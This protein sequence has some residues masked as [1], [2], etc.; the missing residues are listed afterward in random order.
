MR[1]LVLNAGYEPLAVVSFKRALVL[2]LGGKASIIQSDADHPVAGI[3][4]EWDRPSV[5]LLRRYVKV[6]TGRLVPVSRRGE[7]VVYDRR[8]DPE[9]ELSPLPTLP[10][11]GDWLVDEGRRQLTRS[12]PL[13]HRAIGDNAYA[14]N[15]FAPGHGLSPVRHPG[16]DFL[17]AYWFARMT[18]LLAAPRD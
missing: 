3:S 13:F 1:T 11:K 9:S 18:G 14:S 8:V 12:A 5:I 17:H 6:P 7:P 4:G 15:P 16:Q 10:W 2:V